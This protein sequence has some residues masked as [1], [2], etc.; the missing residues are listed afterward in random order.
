M[1]GQV[2]TFSGVVVYT[3]IFGESDSLKPAPSGADACICFT[4]Q[5]HESID[6]QGWR[7]VP[8]VAADPRR[9]AW[10]LRCVP[11][12]LFGEY[13][14][15]IWIDASFTL[16]DLPRLLADAGKAPIAGLRHHERRSYIAEARRL[17]R[18]GQANETDVNRQLE[19]YRRAGFE[20]SH[21][22]ISCLLVRRRTDAVR[23]FNETWLRQIQ[24]YLGDNTQVSLDYSAWANGLEITALQGDRHFNPYARHDHLDHRRR[25]KPYMT[26][27]A[28]LR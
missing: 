10:R 4:D 14:R 21:L 5:H 27:E 9:E 11:H 3:T 26:Q 20:G 6:P 16:I 12:Q 1:S 28:P 18:I 8:W 17:V 22:S 15:V 2:G 7:L 13:S 23:E 25:R 24:G 19:V